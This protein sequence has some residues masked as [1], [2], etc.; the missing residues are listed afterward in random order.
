MFQ[1]DSITAGLSRSTSLSRQ[2]GKAFA[3][4]A[5]RRLEEAA[6]APPRSF[7]GKDFWRLSVS[8]LTGTARSLGRERS[9]NLR[10]CGRRAVAA[11]LCGS[12]LFHDPDD[13]ATT[14]RAVEST[15][16]GARMRARRSSTRP[17]PPPCNARRSAERSWTG[18]VQ[19]MPP[20]IG[21]SSGARAKHELRCATGERRG[22]TAPRWAPGAL[23]GAPAACGSWGGQA[24]RR[25]R[26]S[27]NLVPR[28]PV[29]ARCNRGRDEKNAVD[30]T[31][32]A[33]LSLLDDVNEGVGRN[34]LMSLA[35]RLLEKLRDFEMRWR[36]L[37]DYVLRQ[38][39]RPSFAAFILYRAPFRPPCPATRTRCNNWATNG[40]SSTAHGSTIVACW[41]VTRSTT[42]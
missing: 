38:Q 28:L 33:A 27:G 13:D 24:A 31:R 10:S 2:D 20:S 37:S 14:S 36:L 29:G 11:R 4:A 42:A 30:R 40:R 34:C 41:S 3:I 17:R 25:P 21:V 9:K 39:T 22:I 26:S 8:R 35:P 5:C 32:I 18:T 7:L 6:T 12:Q 19:G 16:R 15:S 1:D 23:A